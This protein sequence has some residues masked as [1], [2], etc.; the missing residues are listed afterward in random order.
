MRYIVLPNE[1]LS[2]IHKEIYGNFS[3]HLGRCIYGGV[4]VGRDSKIPNVN[5]LRQDVIEAMKA[6]KL[7]VLRWP[8][9]C[10]ADS[11]HWKDGVG[12]KGSRKKT[13]NANWGGVVE[14][15]SFGTHEFFELCSLIGCEPYVNGNVGTGTV[16]EMQEWIEYMNSAEISPMADL[17]RENGREEPFRLKYFAVGNENWGCGGSMSPEFYADVYRW[18]QTAI[19]RYS[20]NRVYKIACGS[21]QYKPGPN[22]EWTRVMMEKARDLMDGL[23]LHYYTWPYARGKE[24]GKG[25]STCF[26]EHEYYVTLAKAYYMETL[27]RNHGAI[28]D[29]YDPQKRIGM[30]VDE[31]GTWYDPEPGHNPAFLYQQNTMRDAMVAALTLDIFNKHS[32]RVHMANIAQLANVLQSVVLTD[33]DEM[34]LTP[35]YYVFK[36]YAAHQGNTLVESHIV[37]EC[38]EEQGIRTPY[39]SE[40]ASVNDDG[41]LIV[42]ITNTRMEEGQPIQMRIDDRRVAHIKGELLRGDAAAHNQFGCAPQ[43]ASETFEGMKIVSDGRSSEVS[44]TLPPCSLVALRC[45]F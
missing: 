4:Y 27:V 31:W 20:G 23:S 29:L 7:S 3:E 12:P 43:V 2:H 32:D 28:M 38:Y 11:Y 37:T 9:G 41:T 14:D 30:I 15:N 40:S 13:V 44:F 35:T 45:E 33:G 19:R 17:R 21:G 10:F 42:T 1:Q 22:Y 8:G 24:N 18:Y 6:M 36:M 5:G 25:S 34:V 39:V 26:D 16:Q